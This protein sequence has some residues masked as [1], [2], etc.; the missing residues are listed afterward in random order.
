MLF[1]HTPRVN[2]LGFVTGIQPF[3]FLKWDFLT[4]E[5]DVDAPLAAR[6]QVGHMLVEPCVSP[7]DIP[8]HRTAMLRGSCKFVGTEL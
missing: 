1:Q 8:H 7:F 5:P 6:P 3:S 2:K 4:K